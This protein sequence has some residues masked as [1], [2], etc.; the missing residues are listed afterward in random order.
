[1]TIAEK[2]T[3]ITIS[4]KEILI[5]YNEV[6]YQALSKWRI[7][8]VNVIPFDDGKVVSTIFTFPDDSSINIF[9]NYDN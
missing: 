2:L 9:L 1:M 3:G 7:F 4:G 8:A 6:P 5:P